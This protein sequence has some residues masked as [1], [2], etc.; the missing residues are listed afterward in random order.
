MK[1]IA[2]APLF[3]INGLFSL[4]YGIIHWIGYGLG[5]FP[6]PNPA[7]TRAA[8]M[9]FTEIVIAVAVIYIIVGLMASSWEKKQTWASFLS[10]SLAILHLCGITYVLF[11]RT[12]A[13]ALCVSVVVVSIMINIAIIWISL[14]THFQNTQEHNEIP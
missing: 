5:D 7:E 10:A 3:I 2:L 8:N 11:N 4:A 9:H 12:W 13:G 1:R 6:E 14:K